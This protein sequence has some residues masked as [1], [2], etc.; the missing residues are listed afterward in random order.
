MV[1]EIIKNFLH[2]IIEKI[3]N[4]LDYNYNRTEYIVVTYYYY[5]K[6]FNRR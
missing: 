1:R 3:N 2:Y 5:D 6:I 4:V